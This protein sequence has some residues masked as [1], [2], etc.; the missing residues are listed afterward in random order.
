MI[1]NLLHEQKI[2]YT[3]KKKRKKEKEKE[4]N[5]DWKFIR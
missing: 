4:D 3:I 5:C 2:S 1:K